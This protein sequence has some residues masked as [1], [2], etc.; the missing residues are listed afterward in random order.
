VKQC[1]AYKGRKRPS[2]RIGLPSWS[3]AL[4]AVPKAV[5]AP[6][7]GTSRETVDPYLRHAKLG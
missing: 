4:A 2:Y 5:L 3:C 7:Y 6:D 1:G